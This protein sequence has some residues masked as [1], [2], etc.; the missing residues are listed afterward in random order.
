MIPIRDNNPSKSFPVV[1][2]TLITVNCLV[3]FLQ[4]SL[5]TDHNILNYY[6]GLVPA[7]YTLPEISS[8]FSTGLQ[9]FSL[10]SYMFLH[11]GF[12]HLLGNM[13]SL[14]IFGDNIE[15]NLG[16]IRY[17]I[18]YLLCGA[19]SGFT[20]FLINPMSNIPTIGASGAIAGI[21]GAYFILYPGAKILTLIPIIIIPFFFEIPAF[22][23][24]LFWF[25]LQFINAAGDSGTGSGIAWWAHIGGFAFGIIG[26]KL[27]NSFP[28]MNSDKIIK[29]ITA[30]K[31]TPQ[32]QV[33]SV[34]GNISD[35]NLYG[36]FNITSY[37]ALAGSSK[38]I[39]IPWGF[40]KRI[41]KIKIPSGIRNGQQL[42]LKNK[43]KANDFGARGDIILKVAIQQF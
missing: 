13:W 31:K 27:F 20:H 16:H 21:M 14:Y 9:I 37:E 2:Y 11:G 25:L 6:Y 22:F 3:Y 17:L 7:R 15:D 40:K 36:T 39:N 29:K 18:F 41:F 19:A 8:H 33:V 32:L 35:L 28:E 38:L 10:L 34:K 26:L 12:W 4:F 42:K 5:G 30:K 24:L 43:G 23:F 1:T